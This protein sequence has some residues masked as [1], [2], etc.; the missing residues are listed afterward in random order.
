MSTIDVGFRN[1]YRQQN[2][3]YKYLSIDELG[4]KN[5]NNLGDDVSGHRWLSTHID[6]EALTNFALTLVDTDAH[7][8]P[9]R[10][11]R[12]KIIGYASDAL[13]IDIQ[14]YLKNEISGLLEEA[15]VEN[16]DGEGA[17]ALQEDT[18]LTARNVVD[19]LP[20]YAGKP[21]VSATPHGEV[22]FDWVINRNLMLT[23]SIGPGGKEI[24]FA[25]LFYGARLSGRDLWTG[26]LP[27]FVRYCFER[28]RDCLNE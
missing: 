9:G 6:T 7:Q 12:S 27:Q 26:K 19:D 14:V 23:V 15:G 21:D 2:V 16:W 4:T 24:A 18:V 8:L 13:P 17:L 5:T 3:S 1:T 28:L 22:D 25:G 20:N 11:L 10:F